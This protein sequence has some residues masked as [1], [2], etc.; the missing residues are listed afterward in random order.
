MNGTAPSSQ[1]MALDLSHG[2]SWFSDPTLTGSFLSGNSFTLVKPCLATLTPAQTITLAVTAP[3][4]G[5]AQ[6]VGQASS[7]GGLCLST[8]ETTITVATPLQLANQRLKL[9]I[10]SSSSQTVNLRL[11]SDTYLRATRFSGS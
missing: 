10:S 6:Q 9:T 8:E 2:P 3:D 11:G 7:P 5:N 1:T 4:G